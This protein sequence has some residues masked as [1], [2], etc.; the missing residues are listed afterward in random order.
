MPRLFTAAI[1]EWK[2]WKIRRQTPP[3]LRVL[4]DQLER[5]RRNHW[6]TAHILRRM[7]EIRNEGLKR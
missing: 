4:Q 3:E 2:L 5:A 6:P 1:W 7:K